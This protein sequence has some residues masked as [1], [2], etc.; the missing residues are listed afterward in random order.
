MRV[1]RRRRFPPPWTVEE[2]GELFHVRDAT[3][4]VLTYFY[5]EEEPNRR[6]NMKRLNRE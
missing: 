4:Q 6:S 5:F 2:A 1:V 3:G